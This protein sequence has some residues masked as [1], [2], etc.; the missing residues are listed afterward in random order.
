[1][2][3]HSSTKDLSVFYTYTHNH[4]QKLCWNTTLGEDSLV[5]DR[6]F[7]ELGDAEVLN[8]VCP[9]PFIQFLGSCKVIKKK[10]KE[11]MTSFSRQL[12]SLAECWWGPSS[13]PLLA[14]YGLSEGFS[15]VLHTWTM[16]Q[17]EHWM[18]NILVCPHLF[19]DCWGTSCSL[20]GLGWAGAGLSGCQI[21]GGKV[22]RLWMNTCHGGHMTCLL[23]EPA[24]IK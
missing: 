21:L 6:H 9:L 18:I 7:E 3:N 14:F 12:F 23:P 24:A 16:R 15:L 10:K 13:F 17:K 1:M 8:R 22:I 4:M 2:F 11:K 5:I 19:A 20:L